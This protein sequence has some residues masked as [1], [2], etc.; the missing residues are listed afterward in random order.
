MKAII[1]LLPLCFLLLLAA[2]VPACDDDDDDNDTEHGDDDATPDDDDNQTPGDDDDDNDDQTPADD[3]DDNDDQ[4]PADDDNDDQTPA[5]DDDNDNNDNND[6]DDDLCGGQCTQQLYTSCTCDSDDP[7]HWSENGWC[8]EEFCLE[9]VGTFFPDGSDCSHICDGDCDGFRYSECS[10][11]PADPCGWA[12]NGTCDEYYCLFFI[13]TAF[14]DGSDCSDPCAGDCALLN[15]TAC[16]CDPADPCGWVGDGTCEAPFCMDAVGFSF[17]DAEDCPGA[18]DG[19]CAVHGYTTCTCDPADPCGWADNDFCEQYYC[20]QAVGF[21]FTDTDCTDP[22]AGE[23][24]LNQYTE[25]TC[26]PADVCNWDGD[27]YCQAPFCNAAVGFSFDDS[28][29]CVGICDGE[30]DSYFYSACTCDPADPCGWADNGEC[31]YPQCRFAAGFSFDDSADCP[32]TCQDECAA[33]FYTDCTCDP[34]DPCGWAENGTCEQYSCLAAVGYSFDDTEDC[35][36]ECGGECLNRLFTVCTCD[37]ADPCNWAENGFCETPQCNFNVGFSFDDSIDC[38]DLCEGE[39]EAYF[40]TDCTCNPADTCGW[41]ENGACEQYSCLAAV[42]FTFDDT[43]DCQGPCEG[44]CADRLFT[45]CTCDPADHCGWAENGF[46]ETPLCNFNVGSSFDDSVDCPDLCEG[47]CE[48]FFYTDCT[49]DPADTCGWAEN[50]T[51]EQYSCL[52]AVGFTFDDSVDCLSS[53]T[54]RPPLPPAS[55]Q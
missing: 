31:D 45:A 48:A 46:C 11:D 50:G 14:D 26:D 55:A 40:Y 8:D 20:E 10:C 6:N 52:A 1:L 43:V 18:C 16:S 4:T 28:K 44:E 7:C 22:C 53:V 38:P 12:E 15:F 47:E 5:D 54:L 25:C 27:G 19:Y 9:F 41:A 30:C 33:F 51:C 36:G 3:D 2:A 24:F 37:P 34:A 29:D 21:S 42:G 32:G 13:G 23:C 39:C 17:D 49:C 35:Q